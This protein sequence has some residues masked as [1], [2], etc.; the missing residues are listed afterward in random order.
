MA[1]VMMTS[2]EKE[3]PNSN[4]GSV[5]LTTT[6]NLPDGDGSKALDAT[7]HKTFAVGDQIAVIYMMEEG[8]MLVKVESDPLE[9]GDITNS[10]RSATFTVT[11]TEAPKTGEDKNSLTYIYPASIATDGGGIDY[12]QLNSQDGTLATLSSELDACRKYTPWN[13]GELPKLTLDNVFT[14]GKFIIKN[15]G[16]TDITNTI[17]GMTV[18]DGTNTYTISPSSL[19]TIWV[20]MQPVADGS[21]TITATDGTNN[22]TNANTISGVTLAKGKIYPINVTMEAISTIDY[23]IALGDATSDYVGS[24]VTTD[25]YVYATVAAATAAS[26]TAVAVI[27]YVG[28]AGS[29]DASSASYKGLAIAL[30]DANSGSWCWWGENF[31]NC[32]SS[33]QT[34][35]ITTA[36]GFKNGITCTSTLTSDGHTHAAATAAASNNGT[37][38]PTGA[39]GWFMPSMGQ[40]NLIVQG[41]ASKKAGSAITTDLAKDVENNTYKANN[42]NSVITDAGGTGFQASSSYWASTEQDYAHAWAINFTNGCATMY[43]KITNYYVRSVI[44]F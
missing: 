18:S 29:V 38:A 3:N 40:W 36:L 28:T 20:A 37:A 8:G 23:P 4:G 14:I 21:I 26:K 39:S 9:A 16:G 12:T 32:L 13:G 24:V 10:G 7:G 35:D 6:V 34:S 17:T 15:S 41:L 27:A 19:N 43:P 2:C 5:T 42:L 33:S 25:G 44:A 30:S 22:Y 1:V 31:A 11:L